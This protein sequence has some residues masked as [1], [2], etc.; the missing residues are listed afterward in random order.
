LAYRLRKTTLSMHILDQDDLAD[1]DDAR[2]AIAG[3]YL[4][5]RV[6]IN[7]VLPPSSGVPAKE[8][9]GRGSKVNPCGG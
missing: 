8:P 5:G 2:L 4:I 7:D 1:A 9:I 6:E 3:C